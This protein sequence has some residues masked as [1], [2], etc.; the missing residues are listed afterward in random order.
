MYPDLLSYDGVLRP[1]KE[2]DAL[3]AELLQKGVRTHPPILWYGFHPPSPPVPGKKVRLSWTFI[4]PFLGEKR[5]AFCPT[6]DH[7][8]IH[9]LEKRLLQVRHAASTS[10]SY[11]VRI[12]GKLLS[13]RPYGSVMVGA[14]ILALGGDPFLSSQGDK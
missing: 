5:W 7:S 3:L 13:G 10:D 8:L 9:Y 11:F 12:D 6:R 4:D 2:L 1:P 14:F